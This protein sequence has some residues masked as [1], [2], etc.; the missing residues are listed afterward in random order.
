MFPKLLE[1][2]VYDLPLTLALPRRSFAVR[3]ICEGRT[4]NISYL[5]R[6]STSSAPSGRLRTD[7]EDP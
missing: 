1:R 2:S 7:S 5:A 4:L 6:W 3:I